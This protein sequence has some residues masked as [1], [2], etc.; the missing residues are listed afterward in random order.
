MV[1]VLWPPLHSST[2]TLVMVEVLWP[3]LH[4]SAL[5]LVMVEVLWPPLH[6]SAL[7]LVLLEVPT[8]LHCTSLLCFWC[9]KFKFCCSL[10]A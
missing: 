6:S 7:A 10:E 5:A 9:L 2:L 8:G 4:S 1:G 3:L